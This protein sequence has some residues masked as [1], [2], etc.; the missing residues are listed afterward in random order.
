MNRKRLCV[1]VVAADNDG[2]IVVV[3][4]GGI[5]IGMKNVMNENRFQR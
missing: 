3:G 4:S 1:F 5:G 2:V